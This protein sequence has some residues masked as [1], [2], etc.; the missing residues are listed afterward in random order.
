MS[1][2]IAMPR[3]AIAMALIASAPTH[4]ND[5][6]VQPAAGSGFAVTNAGGA[7][8]RLAWTRTGRSSCPC[9][10]TGRSRT[11]PSASAAAANRAMCA[12]QRRYGLELHRCDRLDPDRY[13]LR[14][15]ADV[16]IAAI[17]RG[18]PGA[19]VERYSLGLRGA[20][21]RRFRVHATVQGQRRRS[22]RRVLRYQ[23]RR[24]KRHLRN[25]CGNGCR[26]NK[27]SCDE[28]GRPGFRRCRHQQ[29][30]WQRYRTSVGCRHRRP[31]R[32]R[33][34][35]VWPQRRRK[36]QVGCGGRLGRYH[37]VL[38]SMGNKCLHRWRA[39]G[40]HVFFRRFRRQ[41]ERRRRLGRK[42]WL[43]RL[44]RTHEFGH[45]EWRRRLRRQQIR[46]RVWS[47]P[48]RQWRVRNK[49]RQQ[50]RIRP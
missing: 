4:A 49:Q 31:Q 8:V 44:A 13:D 34:G 28:I 40:Q 15:R 9:W 38:R 26:G 16:P 14:R 23:Y 45:R 46:G 33:F 30:E 10:S 35:R 48:R 43:R 22:G 3:I 24:R 42:R 17:L 50:W 11:S 39:R 6:T 18:E 32:R 21:G 29:P 12:G 20:A 19:A 1:P 5:V 41:P 37:F 2:H 36:R 7:Q 25:G 47:Q 27:G